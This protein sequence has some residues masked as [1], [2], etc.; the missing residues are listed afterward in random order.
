M[1]LPTPRRLRYGTLGGGKAHR[2][3]RVL[4]AIA[5]IDKGGGQVVQALQ[6]FRALREKVG[7]HL[8]C[9][10]AGGAVASVSSEEGV[11]VVGPLTFPGGILK[12]SRAI[13]ERKGSYD[14][15]QAYDFY[16]AL[17]AARLARA[18]PVVVR[19][20]AHP[21]EDFGSRY[22]G[23]G[24]TVMRL[25]NPWLYSGTTVVVN[26]EHLLSAFPRG[27]AVFIPN[28]VDISR[29]AA[30]PRTDE[31][32][33]ELGLPQAVPLLAFSGKIIPRKN[34]EDLFA[35]LRAEPELHLLLV[36]AT[37]E[38]YYGDRYYRRLCTEFADV[39]PRIHGVGEVPMERI[40]RYLE[41]S[42]VFVFPSRLEGMPNSVLE[43]MAAALPVV[44]SDIPA[45]RQVLT[46][47]TGFL[48]QTFDQLRQAVAH[49][50][51]DEPFRRAMGERGRKLVADRFSIGAA[52]QA[53]L[54]LYEK[55]TNPRG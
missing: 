19:T 15:L 12:L 11:E 2:R 29:F 10:S 49:L 1:R 33:S 22:G 38:P 54:A 42:D 3:M 32:R 51:A 7:G 52:V 24:R 26:A 21:V 47:E 27:K 55:E 53:Y 5:H 28:G 18:H 17:P 34:L 30:V 43:A 16:Y 50:I 37:S 8:L 36:G 13:R 23:V 41:A 6:L 48:Y 20:G 40:P 4:F 44:A 45:H 9:L 25:W 14:L 46:Q 35:L 39:L 31:A